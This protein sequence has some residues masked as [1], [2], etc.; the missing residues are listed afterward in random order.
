M[1]PSDSA[2]SVIGRFSFEMQP[3]IKY[4]QT[5]RGSAG[6]YLRARFI[7][8]KDS[9]KQANELLHEPHTASLWDVSKGCVRV[10]DRSDHRCRI[11][12]AS[13]N[14]QRGCWVALHATTEAGKY[15]SWSCVERRVILF[16]LIIKVYHNKY[17]SVKYILNYVILIVKT[18]KAPNKH[19]A[20][21]I[22]PHAWTVVHIT[23]QGNNSS[24]IRGVH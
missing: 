23:V 19:F 17:I 21:S 3:Y 13:S 24:H 12:Y 10:A 5:L 9:S 7:H 4:G 16:F 18:D 15:R 22:T 1:S 6:P 11:S 2:V 14:R 8:L 20:P